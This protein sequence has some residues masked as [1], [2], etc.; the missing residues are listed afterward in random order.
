VVENVN[1]T[2]SK[3]NDL[4]RQIAATRRRR[5]QKEARLNARVQALKDR[6]GPEI[7]ALKQS[8][9]SLTDQLVKLVVPKFV[10]L[11]IK[12][13]KTIR[14]RHGE[15]SLRLSPESLELSEDEA[16]IIR[17]IRKQGGLR[18]F[19][20]MGKRTLDKAALKK[21]PAFVA[22]IPGLAIVRRQHLS[23]RLPKTQGEIV[24]TADALSTQLSEE[25]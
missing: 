20:R 17:R 4:L 1:E 10:F 7:E 21:D 12:G 22:K 11:A 8:E 16:V 6:D 3:A 9:A 13:T 5:I 24:L 14:L 18:K 2:A 25:D 19:T 23:I 15:I